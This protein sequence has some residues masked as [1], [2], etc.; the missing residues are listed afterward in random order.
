MPVGI[1]EPEL[2]WKLICPAQTGRKVGV[3]AGGPEVRSWGL[4]LGLLVDANLSAFKVT[5]CSGTL[6]L[7][8]CI[9]G[10][11]QHPG[12]YHPSLRNVVK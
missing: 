7:G 2:T 10:A 6:R 1:D 5:L 11:T 4:A 9:S 12:V 8:T 3:R